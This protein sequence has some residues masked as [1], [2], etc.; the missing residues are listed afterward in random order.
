MIPLT[1]K[2]DMC[3]LRYNMKSSKPE[4]QTVLVR[5]LSIFAMQ[6]AAL[7]EARLANEYWLTKS[8]T[9]YTFF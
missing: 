1:G 2:W 3:T 5:E 8:R 9:G 4:K 7:S 6:I